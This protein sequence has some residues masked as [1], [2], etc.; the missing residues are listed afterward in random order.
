MKSI[1]TFLFLFPV[2]LSAQDINQSNPEK[3]KEKMQWFKD[4]KLGIFIHWGIYA[5]EGVSESWSFFNGQISHEDYLKQTEGFTCENYDPE[6]WAKLFADCGYVAVDCIRDKVWSNKQV[7][8]YYA[9]NMILYVDK[10]YLN[11]NEVLKAAYEKT[12]QNLLSKVH[13]VCYL[14]TIYEWPKI[15]PFM[16]LLKAVPR[17]FIR[18]VKRRFGILE[19]YDK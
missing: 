9:Q 13:P 7:A 10:N 19:K 12:N 14:G 11:E 3:F 18:A 16:D 2:L 15:I 8:W 1:L 17:S 5:V 4:A 6:Y